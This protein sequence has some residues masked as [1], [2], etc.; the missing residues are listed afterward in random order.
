[1][2]PATGVSSMVAKLAKTCTVRISP[3]Q[4]NFI[5][6]DKV[7][8]GGVSMWCELEQVSGAPAGRASVPPAPSEPAHAPAPLLPLGELLQRISNG[9]CLSRKQ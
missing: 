7:A 5:L 3:R 6:A 8:S 1:M 4:L 2:T 9:R